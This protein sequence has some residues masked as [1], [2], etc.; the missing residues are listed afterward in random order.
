MSLI[1]SLAYYSIVIA[2]A[3]G[4]FL[5]RGEKNRVAQKNGADHY[6]L[7]YALTPSSLRSTTAVVPECVKCFV[8][9]EVRASTSSLKFIGTS[10]EDQREKRKNNYVY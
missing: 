1:V 8:N 6:C 4:S 10:A 3:Y 7:T 5:N 2:D 9:I